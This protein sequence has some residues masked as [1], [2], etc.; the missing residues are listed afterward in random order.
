[1]G[2]GIR[3]LCAKVP[4]VL[5]TVDVRTFGAWAWGTLAGGRG[6]QARPGAALSAEWGSELPGDSGACSVLVSADAMGRSGW[7][8]RA[9][10]GG[11]GSQFPAVIRCPVDL[12]TRGCRDIPSSSAVSGG[13][14]QL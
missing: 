10:A 6:G 2:L 3:A 14:G 8:P 5:V 4:P 7:S 1:M 13:P 11:S 12:G 9:R